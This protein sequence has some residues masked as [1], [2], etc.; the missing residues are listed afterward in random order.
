MHPLVTFGNSL[1][2]PSEYPGCPL[3]SDHPHSYTSASPLTMPF[4]NL[5]LCIFLLFLNLLLLDVF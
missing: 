1:T 5:E 3:Q 2:G 4:L